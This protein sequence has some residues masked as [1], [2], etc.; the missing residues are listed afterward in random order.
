MTPSAMHRALLRDYAR[1]V[2]HLRSQFAEKRFGLILGAG[3]VTDF[4][5]PMW[6]ELVRKVAADPDV[7]GTQLLKGEASK[8]SLPYQAEMLF[9]HYRKK[10][11]TK[12]A[13]GTSELFVQSVINAGWS[14]ICGKYIYASAPKRLDVALKKH[15]YFS[16]LLPL[17]RG[18]HL[19]ITFNFDD[20]LERA[21]STHKD[22]ADSGRGYEVVTN[23]WPQFRRRNSVIYHPHGVVPFESNLMELPADRF[24][25]AEAAYS[26]QYVGSRGH[27]TSY[28]LGH[29]A[30]NTCLII[31]CSLEDELRNV[32]MRGA[33]INP[34][35]YHYYIHYVESDKRGPS[36]AQ[37]ALI[38]ET[39]FNVYNLITLF[40][41]REK[42]K[43][44]L[45]LLD[46]QQFGDSSFKD[47]A[48]NAGVNWRYN[49]YLTGCI[50]V[51]KST[52]ASQLRSLHAMDEWLEVRP[53]ILAK[54]W[55]SLT[56]KERK[57]ADE[58]I[59]NQFGD[60]N[61]AL[62]DRGPGI[63]I[64]DRPPLDPLAFTPEKGRPAKAK[65]LLD[66]MCPNRKRGTSR[67]EEGTVILLTGDADVLTARVRATGREDYSRERLERM[68]ETMRHIYNRDGVHVID[69]RNLSVQEVTKQ[70][71]DII[72]RASY[73]PCDVHGALEA[74]ENAI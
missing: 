3:V 48:E 23:P 70:V 44:L 51:G 62:R 42:I 69:T 5:V 65:S 7:K 4:N 41:T 71:A 11:R 8:K 19:T 14:K 46:V 33:E 12:I 64:I 56:A 28:L 55:E 47:A 16:S 52:T 61:S 57:A 54:S 63:A 21:L 58:W 45:E 32:L 35:N 15:G 74:Y 27:D 34:G 13:L 24:V 26:A 40:L 60:K 17:V 6:P 20:F 29:F 25:F 38:A 72:H 2:V 50:G 43:A 22:K 67:V 53:A 37:K 1:A 68:Q 59:V 73:K 10:A 39:N 18:S 36:A 9:Q 66:R 31:G 49:F 30:R